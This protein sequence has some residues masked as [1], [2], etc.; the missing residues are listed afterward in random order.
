M[1]QLQ[2]KWN[3]TGNGNPSQQYKVH[4]VRKREEE[5]EEREESEG[6]ESESEGEES[7][8]EEVGAAMAAV[9]LE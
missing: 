1:G 4:L 3:L 8:G 7:E 2:L 5:E 9:R 6:E